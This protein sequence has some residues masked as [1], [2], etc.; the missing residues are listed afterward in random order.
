MTPRIQIRKDQLPIAIIYNGARVFCTPEIFAAAVE[1]HADALNEYR[2][3]LRGVEEDAANLDLKPED[4]R[5]AFP[6]PHAIDAVRDAIVFNGL[7]DKYVPYYELIGPP[8]AEKKQT[9]FAQVTEMENAA[10]EANIPA[11]KRRHWQYRMQDVLASDHQRLTETE[12]TPGDMMAWMRNTR[13]ALDAEF[14]DDYEARGVKQHAIQRW[15]AKL[16][17]DIDDLTEDTVD[18]FVV[19]PF[20]G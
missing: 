3:H 13:P 6:G 5:V 2:A 20:N 11:A 17:A 14:M 4:R 10:I 1:Y 9:L 8:L 7:S 16:H 18:A 19:T 12:D 15:A